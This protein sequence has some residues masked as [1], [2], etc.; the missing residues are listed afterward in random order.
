MAIANVAMHA[1]LYDALEQED[2]LLLS[3]GFAGRGETSVDYMFTE[4]IELVR[5]IRASIEDFLS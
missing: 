4:Q 3:K 1:Y 2:T 5:H